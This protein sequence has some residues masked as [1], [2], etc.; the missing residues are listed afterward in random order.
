MITL[1]PFFS[2]R[3]GLENPIIG[4]IRLSGNV[5]EKWRVGL[6]DIQTQEDSE[7]G[8][9]AE[10]FGV[11]IATQ[12]LDRSTIGMIFVN[13]QVVANLKKNTSIEDYNRNIG[14]EYNYFSAD[15]LWNGKLMYLKSFSPDIRDDNA[16]IASNITYNDNHFL[17]S[18]QA[19]YVG[20]NYNAE[21]G[22]TKEQLH[23]IDTTLKYLI[24]P[25]KFKVLSHGPSIGSIQYFNFD[26]DGIDR[27]TK[28]G[29]EVNFKNRS[30]M[31]LAFEN[32]FIVL[33]IHL[34]P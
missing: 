5:D 28:F 24:F 27:R 6:L 19:E 3:I 20:Q 10:N 25:G 14:L 16:I 22:C 29:Y 32:Q 12:V 26:G 9:P 34:I 31:M 30:E 17:G 2:R 33:Q 7:K 8:L 23:K 15:N 18:L 4:G 21:V 1:D 13:K 11:F